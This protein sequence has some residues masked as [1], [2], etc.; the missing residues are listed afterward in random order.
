MNHGLPDSRKLFFGDLN[1]FPWV[2]RGKLLF[3]KCAYKFYMYIIKTIDKRM[4]DI[5]IRKY[6]Q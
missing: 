5:Q 6:K 3:K 1:V 2:M 4:I